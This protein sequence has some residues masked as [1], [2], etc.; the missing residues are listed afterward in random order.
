MYGGVDVQLH[1]FF[2]IADS[3][4]GRYIPVV[5]GVENPFLV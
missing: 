2:I 4:K 3:I 1:S 5:M